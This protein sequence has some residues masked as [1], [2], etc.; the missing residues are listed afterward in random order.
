MARRW[1]GVKAFAVFTMLLQVLVAAD[2]LGATLG[3]QAGAG[4]RLGFLELCTGE[5]IALL[6]P[7]GRIIP[8]GEVEGRVPGGGHSQA[9]QCPVCVSAAACS[10][11]APDEAAVPV[12]VTG[13]ALP[14]AA[15]D[16]PDELHV[17]ARL[18]E[19]PIR[20]PPAA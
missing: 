6:T 13:L 16:A 17:A 7:D 14:L 5:G 20:A 18:S 19:T 1:V 15:I 10:F 8:A 9:P 4:A 2:H 12:F 11:D 3:A